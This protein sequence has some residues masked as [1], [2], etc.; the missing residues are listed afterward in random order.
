MK[1]CPHFGPCGGCS[2]QDLS[3]EEQLEKK[4]KLVKKW[5][6][7]LPVEQFLPILSSPQTQ[8]HRNKMEY[9]FGDERDVRILASSWRGAGT[10]PVTI[11]A[12]RVASLDPSPLPS[13]KVDRG[14]RS[15]DVASL[16]LGER[17]TETE[18]ADRLSKMNEESGAESGGTARHV[19][20]GLHPKGRFALVT[21]TPECFLLSPE[22][23][24]ILAIVSEWA[25]EREIPVYVRKN[26]E[27]DLRHLVIREGKNT[28]ERMV[29]LV[30]K[31]STRYVEDLAE[32]L[33]NSQ[34]PITTFF[35]EIHDGLSDVAHGGEIRC[36]W[37]NATIHE[38]LGAL[39]LK[40]TAS[41]FMQTN[42]HAAEQMINVLK[43]WKA[44]DQ[45]SHLQ[46][47]YGPQ[48]VV[49][50]YCGSG[51]LGLNLAAREDTLIGVESNPSAVLEAQNTAKENGFHNALFIGG[52]VEKLIATHSALQSVEN[53]LVVVD[54][55]RSGIMT[56]VLTALLERTAPLLYY[57]SCNP[58]SLNRDLLGLTS[59]YRI[60]N[61]Q[62]M[63]FFPHTDHVETAVRLQKK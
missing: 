47:K 1:I 38:K 14:V 8:F 28:G 34:I 57:V 26:G 31:S 60:R 22:A 6:S 42:T 54:P 55:P 5:L 21:P 49:D 3:Y 15:S 23:Q 2:R 50:L 61:V 20:L 40:V 59:K 32:R 53:T 11:H 18:P 29:K 39:H 33:T 7:S 35:W 41:S 37:G 25:T 27:G 56:P 46:E 10:D 16:A 48:K 51:A 44:E 13:E 62:P 52:A 9:S 43:K 58:E 4:E 63:D 36:Y 30:A 12:S 45:P 17:G 19:H 24:K